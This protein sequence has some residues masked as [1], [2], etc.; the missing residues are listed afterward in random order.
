MLSSTYNIFIY[1]LVSVLVKIESLIKLC[2][3]FYD[4]IFKFQK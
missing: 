4:I 2:I 3:L 1:T